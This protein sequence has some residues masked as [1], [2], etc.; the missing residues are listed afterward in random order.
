MPKKTT[1]QIEI[2]EITKLIELLKES[3][4]NEIKITQGDL[5]IRLRKD[6][7]AAV[8]P[9]QTLAFPQEVSAQPQHQTEP[10]KATPTQQSNAAPEVTGN[11]VKSPMVGTFYAAPS[12]EESPFIKV[13]DTVKKGQTICIIEAMKTMNQIEAE[14][15]GTLQKV[16]VNDAQPVEFG[17]PLFVIQ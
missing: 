4:I 13:G 3:G 14:E 16:L 5:G 10:P 2:E 12:P 6:P 11:T 7:P 8:A 9:L 15:D 1:L 17:E